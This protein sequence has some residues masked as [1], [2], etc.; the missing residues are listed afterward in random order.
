[1]NTERRPLTQVIRDILN[2]NPNTD[3]Y[4]LVVLIKLEL[5]DYHIAEIAEKTTQYSNG[6]LDLDTYLVSILTHSDEELEMEEEEMSEE[7]NK[8]NKPATNQT[9]KLSKLTEEDLSIAR[10]NSMPSVLSSDRRDVTHNPRYIGIPMQS[11]REHTPAGISEAD[12]DQAEKEAE[13]TTPVDN[14]VDTHVQEDTINTNDTP[15][16]PTSDDIIDMLVKAM[17]PYMNCRR[18][19]VQEDGTNTIN[20]V[21]I[22]VTHDV[23]KMI[24]LDDRVGLAKLMV[25]RLKNKTIAVTEYRL[26]GIYGG[27]GEPG[28]PVTTRNPDTLITLTPEKRFFGMSTQTSVQVHPNLSPTLAAMQAAYNEE[29]VV[30]DNNPNDNNRKWFTSV[31]DYLSSANIGERMA[32]LANKVGDVAKSVAERVIENLGLAAKWSLVSFYGL[33]FYLIYMLHIGASW[34]V[35]AAIFGTLAY[36]A[37]WTAKIVLVN[38]VIFV[39]LDLLWETIE[40]AVVD[41]SERKFATQTVTAEA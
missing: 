11:V 23:L 25:A 8:D 2:T 4:E 16:I 28:E 13:A 37:V 40:G 5:E 31:T 6:N 24:A 34:P 12:L 39:L 19:L 17:S 41:S 27:H 29:S 7:D 26:E 1:M 33:W 20:R 30:K 32:N 22:P 36:M 38:L 10:L 14:S 21:G 35:G 15:N 9:A 3:T 18:T